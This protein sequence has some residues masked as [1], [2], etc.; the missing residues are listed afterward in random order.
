M[1][2][3][4]TDMIHREEFRKHSSVCPEIPVASQGKSKKQASTMLAEVT[5][6]RLGLQEEPTG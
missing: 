6:T 1:D 3:K 5:V 2:V 4:L